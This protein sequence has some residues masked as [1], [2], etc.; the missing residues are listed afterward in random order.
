MCGIKKDN[1]TGPAASIL[2]LFKEMSI[3][4]LTML[5]SAAVDCLG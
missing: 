3:E 5:Q 2:R 1:I 4:S